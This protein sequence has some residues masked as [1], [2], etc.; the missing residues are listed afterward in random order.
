MPQRQHK[1]KNTTLEQV[2]N[3][4]MEVAANTRFSKNAFYRSMLIFKK[5]VEVDQKILSNKKV[6]HY[7]YA[8]LLIG[9]KMECSSLNFV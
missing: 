6:T 3:E 2:F 1:F 4:M 9:V 5:L 8:S 7:V